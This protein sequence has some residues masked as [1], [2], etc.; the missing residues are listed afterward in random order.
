MSLWRVTAQTGCIHQAFYRNPAS[1]RRWTS[2]GLMLGQRRRRWP[3]IKSKFV[4]RLVFA[5]KALRAPKKLRVSSY[6]MT[7]DV[8]LCGVLCSSVV[9]FCL[10]LTPC[11]DPSD[12]VS[13]RVTELYYYTGVYVH[14]THTSLIQGH[15]THYVL[16]HHI[17]VSLKTEHWN[18]RGMSSRNTDKE[19]G[20]LTRPQHIFDNQKT[21]NDGFPHIYAYLYVLLW[22]GINYLKCNTLQTH[23]K[24]DS[25]CYHGCL[26]TSSGRKLLQ[27]V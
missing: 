17:I 4:R 3:D 21:N 9:L 20:T 23:L 10:A 14:K 1:T 5:G 19:D 7:Y 24:A 13:G 15:C 16:C 22:K 12:P 18:D 11:H 26:A 8:S 6:Q 27:F 2:V 25:Y